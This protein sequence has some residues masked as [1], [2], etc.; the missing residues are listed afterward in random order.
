MRDRAMRVIVAVSNH[1]VMWAIRVGLLGS[2]LSQGMWVIAAGY[3]FCHAVMVVANWAVPP[4]A[5]TWHW[6]WIPRWKIWRFELL[7]DLP[8]QKEPWRGYDDQRD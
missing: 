1:P 5:S 7:R 8:G 2:F 4:S 3:F 6:P